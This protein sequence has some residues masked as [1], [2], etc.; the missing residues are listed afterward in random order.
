MEVRTGRKKQRNAMKQAQIGSLASEHSAYTAELIGI[1][2]TEN[3]TLT[4]EFEEQ[5]SAMDQYIEK[6][7]N[8]RI[9][10]I[11]NQI[12]R[13]AAQIARLKEDRQIHPDASATDG[14]GDE[15]AEKAQ[16]DRIKHLEK[17]LR[18]ANSQRLESL[19][20]ARSQL[21][22]CVQTLEE[23]EDS[24]ENEISNLRQRLSEID[25]RYEE[26]VLSA[27]SKHRMQSDSLRRKIRE[28]DTRA[29]QTEK[30]TKQSERHFK[31]D[32]ALLTDEN[33]QLRADIANLT[34]M[35]I[36]KR[37]NETSVQ[38][39]GDKRQELKRQ[40]EESESVLLKA[41]SD[42]SA[43]KREICRISHETALAERRAALSLM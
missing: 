26:K 1:H 14:A 21:D 39:K 12:E 34:A 33:A 16:A 23:M 17:L 29:N 27:T 38:S 10:P 7:T 28:A 24:H 30:A 36:S 11:A 6:K 9:S 22:E 25:S 42:S 35:E 41:R 43:L 32:I 5:V 2:K 13:T 3:E 31:K 15:L 40:L 4:Q 19:V 37:T 8:A 20:E 18:G